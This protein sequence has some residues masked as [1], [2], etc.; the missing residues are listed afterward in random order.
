[1]FYV[2]HTPICLSSTGVSNELG[3][4]EVEV[5]G[6]HDG[7]KLGQSAVGALVRS[8][9]KVVVNPFPEG[10]ALMKKAHDLAV[11]F[12]YGTRQKD[13][14]HFSTIVQNQP[15]IK[16]QVDLNGTRVAA[17]H[18]LLYSELRMN[19]CLKMY[20]TAKPGLIAHPPSEE[21][22]KS[23]A[24]IEGILDITKWCTTLM[25]YEQLYTAAFGQVCFVIYVLLNI[26][27]NTF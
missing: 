13:L 12:S 17:Q 24:E 8:K 14:L 9:K 11:H 4:E 26:P 20:I 22:W 27:L 19:R 23:L 1:M 5:C 21:E 6:M 25:Q 10:Q 18:S 15:T 7:D 2:S 3:L 16:L